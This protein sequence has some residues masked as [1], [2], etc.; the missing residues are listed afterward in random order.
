MIAQHSFFGAPHE[1]TGWRETLCMQ[2]VWICYAKCMK[3]NKTKQLY[4]YGYYRREI[5][6]PV[7]ISTPFWIDRYCRPSTIITYSYIFPVKCRTYYCSFIP[8][9]QVGSCQGAVWSTLLLALGHRDNCPNQPI[10][11]FIS[12]SQSFSTNSLD[13]QLQLLKGAAFI[14]KIIYN[15]NARI[16]RY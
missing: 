7:D 14:N 15:I 10:L 9:D 12:T 11:P 13:P 3:C 1:A 8:Q 6:S 5:F 16:I 4:P 2:S